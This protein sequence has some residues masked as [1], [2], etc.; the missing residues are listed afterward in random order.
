MAEREVLAVAAFDSSGVLS[1]TK[2]KRRALGPHDVDIE[3]HFCGICHSDLHQVRA[4]WDQDVWYPMVSGHEMVG[5]VRAVGPEVT[6]FEVGDRAGCGVFYDA[7]PRDKKCVYCK[8]GDEQYCKVETHISYNHRVEDDSRVRIKNSPY[9]E[10][11]HG[12]QSQ[13]VVCD[14]NFVLAIPDEIKLEQAGPLLCAGITVYSPLVH[15][16]AREGGELRGKDFIVGVVGFGGLGHMAVKYALAMGCTVKVISTSPRKRAAVEKLGAQFIV[17][18]DPK[19]MEANEDTIDLIID[20]ASADH[21]VGV[22]LELLKVDAQ[23]VLVGL[24]PNPVQ[25]KAFDVV[26]RRLN[27]GGSSIGG[28]R[29]TIEMLRFSADHGIVPDV[30]VIGVKDMNH[31]FVALSK[32]SNPV[33]RFVVDLKTLETQEV[34][35]DDEIDFTKWSILG[36]IK[37]ESADLHTARAKRM[38]TLHYALLGGSALAAAAGL[39]Y[40][41]LRK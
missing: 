4:E 22:Y 36:K 6:K 7:C 31:A 25:I 16:G 9:G 8:R 5:V 24:P 28:I 35:P 38:K 29:E 18:K 41:F 26:G 1:K 12:G 21:D 40:F 32:N 15:Y 13:G 17:S 30:E 20:T 23:M 10:L 14:E 11:L 2:I 3:L 19:D 33:N 37:P 39:A 27:F 34:E